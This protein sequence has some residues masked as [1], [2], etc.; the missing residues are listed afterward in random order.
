MIKND[1]INRMN[2]L[3][4]NRIPF[5][6]IIDFDFGS[7]EIFP[8]SEIDKELILYKTENYS[9]Q[10]IFEKEKPK[11]TFEK[12]PFD[13]NFYKNAFEYVKENILN[14]NSYLL[15]LT[16]PT[17]IKTNLTLKDIFNSSNAKYKLYFEDKFVCFSPEIFV[18]IIENKIFSYPMKGTIDANIPNALQIILDDEKEFAEHNTI[19][20]LIRNDL[21]IVSKNVGVTKFRYAD[22]LKTNDKQLIQISS[23]IC[24]ELNTDW[25]GKIGDIIAK[26]L[27]AGSV[28]GAPKKKT[29][30]I[31]KEAEKYDRG[32]YTGIFGIYDGQNLESAVMIRFIEKNGDRFFFKSGGGITAMS[33]LISEY[34]EL[35][36]KVYVPIY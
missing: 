1:F 14:G 8:I 26:L 36:D 28:T 22:Y 24:G 32:F 16:F 15:N 25:H 2:N 20:D 21:S 3:G 19:V 9:N 12:M 5:L 17:E 31:I 6:F 13:F 33:D 35:V 10:D 27:P 7:P 18:K 34:S 23:E 11:F 4:E 30:E 29:V